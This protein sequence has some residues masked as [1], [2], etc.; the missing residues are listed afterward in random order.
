MLVIFKMYKLYVKSI[1]Q[2]TSREGIV[3]PDHCFNSKGVGTKSGACHAANNIMWMV[4][5]HVF[6][7]DVWRIRGQGPLCTTFSSREGAPLM[8][9]VCCR[10]LMHAYQDKVP[11]IPSAHP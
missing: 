4:K 9:S 11:N 10:A 3:S 7:K 5:K 6:R 1:A 2:I 8:I